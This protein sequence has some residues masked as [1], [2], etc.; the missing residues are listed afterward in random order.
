MST[1]DRLYRSSPGQ[2]F[3]GVELDSEGGLSGK[4]HADEFRKGY[5]KLVTDVALG[6]IDSRSTN[7]NKEIETYLDRLPEDDKPDAK[8][9]GTFSY[10]SLLAGDE[11]TLA[12]PTSQP[13][14][15]APKQKPER[16]P[17]S[18]VPTKIK[19]ELE[20]PRI[21]AVFAELKKLKVATHPNATALM[22]RTLLEMC[23]SYYLDK[24]KKIDTILTKLQGKG[25]K[26]DWYPSLNQMLNY[27]LNEDPD[28][29]NGST[30][31]P[32]TLKV[33]RKHVSDN[34][35]FLSLDSLNSFVHNWRVAP[36][37]AHLRSMWGQFEELL[38]VLLVE[39][40]KPTPKSK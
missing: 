9:S 19:C 15:P 30:L 16:I 34:Q 28:I 6:N 36:T 38:M 8:R 18:I 1:L 32:L 25:K 33:L 21:N 11:K 35:S 14:L 17:C 2:K 24:T 40:E 31:S 20:C 39:P 12:P 13:K 27:L 37:D 26:E 3:L 4:I 10:E 22:L 7:N 5:K 29:T 23:V